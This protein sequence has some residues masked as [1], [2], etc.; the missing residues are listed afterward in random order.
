[1]RILF[2]LPGFHRHERGAEVALMSIA[3]KLSDFGHQVTL[4]G[5][6][7]PR[8][9][10]GYRFIKVAC[11]D[12]TRFE[13]FPSMPILRSEYTYEELTFS[14]GLF[15][16]FDPSNYDATLT[17]SYPFTNWILRRSNGARKHPP[18]VFIT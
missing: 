9:D 10:S 8:P 18:H 3:A 13:R 4:I 16:R 17:C 5:S 15:R 12:R 7:E 14:V 2:A 1:M 11:V 6:G